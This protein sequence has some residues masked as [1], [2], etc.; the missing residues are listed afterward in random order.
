MKS[1]RYLK[2]KNQKTKKTTFRIVKTKIESQKIL[3]P[4]LVLSSIKKR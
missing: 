4:W 2:T 3:V 1:I